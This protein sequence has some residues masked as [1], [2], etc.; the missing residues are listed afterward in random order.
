MQV[1]NG[2]VDFVFAYSSEG[3]ETEIP[4]SLSNELVVVWRSKPSRNDYL[5]SAINPDNPRREEYQKKLQNAF[6]RLDQ[7]TKD[8]RAFLETYPIRFELPTTEF[9]DQTNQR[10]DKLLS[11]GGGLP[12]CEAS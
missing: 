4:L 11:V 12:K 8:G 6:L 9:P 1:A 10:I 7:T 2:R 3:K 5:I